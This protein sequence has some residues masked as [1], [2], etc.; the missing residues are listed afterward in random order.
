[1][2]NSLHRGFTLVELLVVIALIATFASLAVPAFSGF[3][4]RN[5]SET[6]QQQL[7]AKLSFTRAQAV[8][9]R[10]SVRLC[11]S[12]DGKTCN[13]QW[14]R[15]LLTL[16]ENAQEPLTYHAIDSAQPLHWKGARSNAEL[17]FQA[18]GTTHM[19]NGRFVFCG[20]NPPRVAWQI[21]VN[22]QGR[23]RVVSGLER[24][25]ADVNECS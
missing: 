23:H 16:H 8:V 24:G 19:S 13:G 14:S 12:D 2:N 7:L 4:Q 22:L 3:I 17:L 20:T 15:G 21:V 18:N 6:V 5:E 1:M 11:G 9:D 10:Q 25:Q